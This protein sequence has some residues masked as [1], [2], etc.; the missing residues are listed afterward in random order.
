M[1]APSRAMGAD[2]VCMILQSPRSESRY[3]KYEQSWDVSYSTNHHTV[4]RP[5]ICLLFNRPPSV[6]DRSRL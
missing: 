1:Y 6:S 2:N 3:F 5:P 4:F